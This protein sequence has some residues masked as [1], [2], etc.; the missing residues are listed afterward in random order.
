[1]ASESK[2]TLYPNPEPPT[3]EP[4]GMA[5]EQQN[6]EPEVQHHNTTPENKT[7]SLKPCDID[8]KSPGDVP[9]RYLNVRMCSALQLTTYVD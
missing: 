8:E 1:M 3:Y 5:T 6:G 2:T 7:D 4:L 9:Q